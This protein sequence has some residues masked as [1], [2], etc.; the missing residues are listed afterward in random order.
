M[1]AAAC[2]GFDKCPGCW[3][4]REGKGIHTGDCV[5]RKVDVD[6]SIFPT[7]PSCPFREE[8]QLV[9][10]YSSCKQLSNSH[11]FWCTREPKGDR[12]PFLIQLPS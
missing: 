4:Q 12:K 9:L 5:L 7:H 8:D 1:Q 3:S 2:W 10:Q 6:I 11:S